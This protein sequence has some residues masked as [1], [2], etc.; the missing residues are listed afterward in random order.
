MLAMVEKA[1]SDSLAAASERLEAALQYTASV[2]SYAAGPTQGYFESVSSIAS[3]R[4]S[5]GLSHATAQFSSQPTGSPALDGARRQYYE[6]IGLAH[7]RYSEFLGAASTAVYGPEQG[8]FASIASVASDSAASVAASAQSYASGAS[9]SAQSAAAKAQEAAASLASQ[10]SSGVIGSE[11]AWTES[12][13]SQASQNWEALIAKASN[14]VYGAPTPWAQSAYSQVG[15]YAAQATAQ[16]AEQAAAVQALISELVIGK[17]P[18]FTDSVMA[19]FTSAYYTGLPAVVSSVNSIASENFEAVTSYAGESFEVASEYA[20][21][22]YASASSVVESVFVPPPAI[23]SMTNST[24]LSKVPPWQSTGRRRALSR[25]PASPS[26]MPT[27]LSS[28]RQVKLSTEL[29]KHPKISQPWRPALRQLSAK[30]SSA[31]LQPQGTQPL[32]LMAQRQQQACTVPSHL[33]R[34]KRQL[35]PLRQPAKRCTDR[36]RGP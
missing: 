4:L 7:A 36:N 25:K 2:K 24:P 16:A 35:M 9:D 10:V 33:W 29:P 30:P 32:H 8:T 15:E 12:V 1:Y 17:E 20:A 11:T 28:R 6:A 19:R 26:P 34:V 13:A 21:E 18:D 23:E 27:P 31:L 14:Q 22:A 3:S 5:E